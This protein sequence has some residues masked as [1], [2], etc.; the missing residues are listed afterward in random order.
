MLRYGFRI[1]NLK[2]MG[3][4][5]VSVIA[6]LS[7]CFSRWAYIKNLFKGTRGSMQLKKYQK[8]RPANP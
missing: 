7:V 3:P 5:M 4:L 2:K 8:L 6:R 1:S